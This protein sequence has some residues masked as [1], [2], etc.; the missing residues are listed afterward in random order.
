M[1]QIF[2]KYIITIIIILTF[3]LTV[4]PFLLSKALIVVCENL[5]DNTS[6]KI[7]LVKPQI[8]TS[9]VPTTGIKADSVIIK[10]KNSQD[11][12]LIKDLKI[13]FRLLPLLSGRIHINNFSSSDISLDLLLNKNLVLDKNFFSKLKNTKIKCDSIYIKN[14]KTKVYES[15]NQQGF[16][17]LA[18]NIQFKKNDRFVKLNLKSYL[19]VEEKK[20]DLNLNLFLHKNNIN[21]SSLS[22]KLSNFDISPLGKIFKH[23]LPKDLEELRGIIDIE[24][25][26]EHMVSNLIN[27]AL[28]KKD[29]S[30]SIILPDKL[31]LKSD[32]NLTKKLLIIDQAELKSDNI[33]TVLSGKIS[34]YIDKTLT[35]ITLNIRINSSKAEDFIKMLPPIKTTDIDI[36]KLKKYKFYGDVIGNINIKG[37]IKEPLINGDVFINNGILTKPIPNAKGATIK[38]SF[39]GKY[40]NFDVNVPAGISEKVFV[41]GGVEIYNVKYSD[42]HIWSTKNVNLEVAEEKIVPIHEILNFII[43]PVPIMNISG[44]GN[45]DIK[46]KGN[47]KTPHVWGQFNCNNV[48]TN[49]KGMPDLILKNASAE[50]KFDD[51]NAVFNLKK[52]LINNKPIN[53]DGT[54]NLNGKFDFDVKTDEQNLSDLFKS[55]KTSTMIDDIR[56]MIPSF[57]K[58]DGLTNLTLKVYGQIKDISYIKF[59]ENFFIKG[60]LNLLG[61]DIIYQN[62]NISDAKGA[63]KFDGTNANIDINSFIGKSP[64]NFNANIKGPVANANISIPMLNLYDISYDDSNKDIAN[65]TVNLNAKYNGRTD[66][67]EYDKLDFSAKIVNVDEKNK[68]Q[69]SN[70]IINLKN[71][72]LEIKNIN[73]NFSDTNS[74]FYINLKAENLFD[75]PVFNGKVQLKD[76]ELPI[77]N[78]FSNYTIIPQNIRDSLKKVH[79]DKGK[80][81]L[82]STISNNSVNASTDIGGLEFTYNP[83]FVSENA[84]Y[85]YNIPMKVIN[86]SIYLRKNYLGLNKINIIAD[87]MPLLIDGGINNIFTKQDFNIYINSKPKQDFIDKYINNNKIY[88][89]K[90]KGDIVYWVRMKGVKNDYNI[91]SEADIAKDSSIYYL[92]ATVGDIE[93]AIILNLD[94][95]VLKQNVL[96]IKEFSYDKLINSQGKRQT[97]LN[98]LKANGGIDV[99]QDDLVFHDLKI[100]TSNPTDAKIFNILFRKPNI[101]QGQFTSDL[102][103]NGRLSNPRLIGTFHI[104]ETNIPFMDITMKN[105]SFIF[106]DKTIELSSKGE[107]FG[108]EVKFNGL[109][110][111]KLTLPYYIE[112]ADLHTKILDLN[113]ITEK[114][115]MAHVSESNAFDTFGNFDIKN[116]IIKQLNLHAN[117]IKL[118]N[119]TAENVE[120]I[121]SLNEKNIFNINN[122]K[123]DIAQGSLEGQFLYNMKNNNTSL[124]LKANNINANDLS[125]ALFDLNN[126]IYG[127]LTGEIEL[128]CD[129][130]DFNKC[131]Q[132]LNGSTKFNVSDGRMPKLG[133]LEYL[134]KAGNLVKGGIT[135]LSINS[136]IDILT[137]L[138]TGN[139]SNIFGIFSIKDGIAEDIQISTK[140]DNLSLFMYGKYNFATSEADMEVLGLLSKKIAT[141]FGPIGN[142][143]INTLFNVIPGVDLTKNSEILEKINKIPGIELNNKSFRKFVADIKGNI[144]GENYVTSFKWIN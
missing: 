21:K 86:G 101:K 23:Y 132:T 94:M 3:W 81:N 43:G 141:L 125:I 142:V 60:M 38:L 82:N 140:G 90:L 29:D 116:T 85:E 71:N 123:F 53:I 84:D 108:N 63:I 119:L 72:K 99:Y 83:N 87:N 103:F 105:L 113:Y 18:E 100:K 98:M 80:I 130:K 9:I 78:L 28:I 48:K 138:K 128:S 45:I 33:N 56:K 73:G 11:N 58:V 106:R 111:N 5:S 92:G 4:F 61:N 54:C 93:N 120:A 37:D 65:I 25:D 70:G 122:F 16:T 91:I 133:S 89:I 97:R 88:P 112:K 134:L 20:S 79:F 110:K 8:Y 52:G 96:K 57:E 2:S 7:E 12:L 49:F 136:V 24:A 22:I 126:Q 115:K 35:S 47:R 15:E 144:N 143:S 135:S 74:T 139:F 75:K 118:R 55:I 42:M 95:N 137:P 104:V 51:E 19:T 77:I 107:V 27:C 121:T 14:L 32:F 117:Q 44:I 67:I 66:N 114:L 50:L 39:K 26:K 131:M 129:G 10:S 68:L 17:Y 69:I 64:F 36:Y 40:L 124:N 41:K 109:L 1:K 30:K 102:K 13:K 46:V 31:E 59:N 127:D 62:F 34:N 6:Y 76:F